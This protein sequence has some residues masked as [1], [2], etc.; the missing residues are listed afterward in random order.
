MA[1][2]L[3]AEHSATTAAYLVNTLR[4]AGHFVVH[5]DNALDAWRTSSHEEF[6]VLIVSVVMPGVDGF[7]L[8]QRALQDNPAL[9]VIFITGFAAV[10]LDPYATPPYA[11]APVTTQPFHLTE[12]VGH[13][14]Y[15]MGLSDRPARATS[16]SGNVIYADFGAGSTAQSHA[17]A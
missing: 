4:R 3:I 10:A 1:R 7:V 11:P 16:G 12:I 13:V 6:D 9:Q 2:I 17:S 5:A 8:A 14:R 15:L